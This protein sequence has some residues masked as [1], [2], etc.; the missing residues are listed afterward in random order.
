MR[1]EDHNSVCHTTDPPKI[2]E[3]LGRRFDNG[4]NAFWLSHGDQKFPAINL[5]V[6][7]NL[8]YLHYFPNEDHAGFAS[9]GEL[10]NLK[11]GGE[12]KFLLENFVD[13][14]QIVNEYIV[15]FADALKAAQEF[16]KSPTLPKS[17]RWDEL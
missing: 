1:I 5:L 15:L 11:A 14:V 12:T 3:A 16:A 10:K 8:A 6:R 2:D 4:I 9:V 7:G 17:I 13:S